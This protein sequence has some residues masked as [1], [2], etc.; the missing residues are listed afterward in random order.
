MTPLE[1]LPSGL[2]EAER[3]ARL[4]KGFL[5]SGSSAGIKVSGGPDMALV[6]VEAGP[7]AVAATFTS[8]RMPAAAVRMNQEHLAATE[9]AG[10]G[11]YG[12][13]GAMMATSGC[14]NAAT[15]AAGLADQRSLAA[16]LA[17]AA[18]T[19]SEQVLAMTTGLIGT[20]LPVERIAAAL[21]AKSPRA[22]VA[23]T[24][25]SSTSPKPCERP[26][27]EPRWQPFDWSCRASTGPRSR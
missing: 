23:T 7:A 21:R 17:E 16:T 6:V 26:T 19:S 27:R 11:R 5:A 14:A 25:H 15:G 2:P 20:R 9:P 13:A 22:S 10:A 4:P 8:N 3:T 12:W 1:R 18:G 24:R